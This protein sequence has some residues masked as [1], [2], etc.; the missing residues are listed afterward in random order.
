MS[1]VLIYGD[2]AEIGGITLSRLAIRTRYRGFLSREDEVALFRGDL[3]S[4]LEAGG[5]CLAARDESGIAAITAV[6][7]LAWDSRHFGVPMG[8][9]LIAA[10]AGCSGAVL[11]EVVEAAVS[12]ARA[13]LGLCHLSA[14]MDIDDYAC[15]NA[16]LG[17]GFELLDVKRQYRWSSLA[18]V[19]APKFLSRVRPYEAKDRVRVM[20]MVEA[21]R[22]ESRFSRDPALDRT[23]VNRLYRMW[24][25]QLLDEPG[26]AI[27]VVFERAGQVQGCG[28]V[29]RVELQVPGH[30]ARLMDRGLYVSG[31]GGVGGYYPVIYGLAARALATYDMVQTSVSLNNHAATRV[32]EHMRGASASIRYALRLYRE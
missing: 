6:A 7:P 1:S 13:R 22:F 21:A 20:D 18:G 29:E 28:A 5:I 15:L 10:D 32:L 31:P 16:L 17:R 26:R 14:E 3:L 11:M 24:F 27:V 2:A 9:L 30:A 4:A 23:A 25:E 8:R 12:Q 19:R